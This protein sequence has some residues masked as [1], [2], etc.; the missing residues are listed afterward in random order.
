[1]KPQITVTCKTCSRVYLY[2]PQHRQGHNRTQCNSCVVNLRRIISKEQ[3]VAYKGGKCIKCGYSKCLRVLS[4]HHR[5]KST[6][7]FTISSN[8]FKSCTLLYKE[9]DKCDLL[10]LNC[11]MELEDSLN[12]LG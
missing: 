6:K 8:R 2:N 10:C 12:S 9:L 11:H 1:M 3:A 7:T 5:D 4:F